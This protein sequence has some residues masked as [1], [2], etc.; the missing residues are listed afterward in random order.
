M[1]SNPPFRIA[2][3]M[4]RDEVTR[5]VGE[6]ERIREDSYEAE[7]EAE[8]RRLISEYDRLSR[9]VEPYLDGKISYSKQAASL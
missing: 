4:T 2:R 5:I 9:I 3:S 7:T 6:M 8:E 1:I